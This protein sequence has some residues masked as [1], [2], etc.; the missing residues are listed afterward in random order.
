MRP[1]LIIER[2]AKR[3]LVSR[4]R[5]MGYVC[6]IALI[7]AGCRLDMHI[8]PKYKPYSPTQFFDD[9]RSERPVVPGTVA[10]GQL[11]LD[12]LLY[13]GKEN[14]VLANRFPFPITR[15]DLERGRERYNIYC[16]PCHDYTGSGRGMIIQRGFPQPPS[17]HI[18]RL[19]NAPAGHFFDVMTRG[20]GNMYSYA[21]RVEPEDRWRIAAYIRALQL[22][23]YARIPDVPEPER[24]KLMEENPGFTPGQPK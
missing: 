6:A 8:Q 11:R 17:Y 21:A 1:E 14:G 9:G 12:E 5:V 15:A 10:R 22:A 18:D 20:L 4:A 7:L 2:S 3:A 13:T 23:E 16:S 19:R 24:Q